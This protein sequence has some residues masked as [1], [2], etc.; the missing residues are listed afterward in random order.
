MG[1]VNTKHKEMQKKIR[2]ANTV[3]FEM[4]TIWSLKSRAM[5]R[6]NQAETCSPQDEVESS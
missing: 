5:I 3:S 6:Y 2:E 4:S 1:I